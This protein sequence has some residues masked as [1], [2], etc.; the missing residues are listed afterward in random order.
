VDD[1]VHQAQD[2]ARALEALEARPVLVEA[3]EQL[4]VDRVGLLDAVLVVAIARLAREVVG[5][6]VVEG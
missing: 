1:G 6:A 2:A 3:V 4:G 5:M